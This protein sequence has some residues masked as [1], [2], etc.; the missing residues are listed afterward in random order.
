MGEERDMLSRCTNKIGLVGLLF[1]FMSSN[2]DAAKSK[3]WN[4][5]MK[6]MKSTLSELMRD[7]VLEERVK[8]KDHYEKIKKNTEKLVEMSHMPKA[9]LNRP[10]LDPSITIIGKLFN[11]EVSRAAQAISAGHY[12][13]G[14]KMLRSVT[15]YCIACHTR[16]SQVDFYDPKVLEIANELNQFEKADFLSAVQSH[17][18]ALGAYQKIVSDKKI[19]KDLPLKWQQS[20]KKGL[21]IAIRAKSNPEAADRLLEAALINPNVPKG[22]IPHLRRWKS[23]V[24]E[25]KKEMKKKSSQ[26]MFEL[27]KSLLKRGETQQKYSVD[28]SSFV[29]FLRASASFHEYLKRS[30]PKTREVA[31]ALFGL[32]VTYEALSDLELWSLHE[33]YYESC[34]DQFPGSDI[35]QSCFERY[36]NSVVAGYSGSSGTHLPAEIKKKLGNLKKMSTKK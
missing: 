12:Q 14:G 23:G 25:W 31:E 10:D 7:L 3:D 20:L 9:E 1:V 30:K 13:Y 22:F 2:A 16:S 6:S 11:E 17:Q 8:S 24:E 18:A 28:D 34:I 15:K 4:T 35:S 27:A 36:E 26:N 21:T 19:A 29:D 32:G 33:I 5:R